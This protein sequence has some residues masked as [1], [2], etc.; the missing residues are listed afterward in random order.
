MRSR[1]GDPASRWE[2]HDRRPGCAITVGKGSGSFAPFFRSASMR[3]ALGHQTATGRDWLDN[4]CQTARQPRLR[5]GQDDWQDGRPRID[6]L[7][8]IKLGN[9]QA[10]F[11]VLWSERPP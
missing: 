9:G 4:A 10:C 11:G 1:K 8:E 3:T 2:M 5:R 6:G 7:D